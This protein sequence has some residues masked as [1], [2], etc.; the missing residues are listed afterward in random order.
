MKINIIN[1]FNDKRKIHHSIYNIM[2]HCSISMHFYH[3]LLNKKVLFFKYTVKMK[4]IFS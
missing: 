2:C 1:I 3:I 4:A